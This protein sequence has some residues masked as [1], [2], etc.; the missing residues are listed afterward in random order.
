MGGVVIEVATAATAVH[1]VDAVVLEDDTYLVL[2][3]E[4]RFR[5]VVEHPV[6]IW[7]EIDRKSV[8]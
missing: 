4:P 5:E 8:V 3:A 2:S 7:T 6:R 1:G